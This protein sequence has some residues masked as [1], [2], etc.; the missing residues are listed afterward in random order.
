M[1]S[2]AKA[3]LPDAQCRED[4]FSNTWQRETY[5]PILF[6]C[7][8]PLCQAL[9]KA[10]SFTRWMW[11]WK[12]KKTPQHGFYNHPAFPLVSAPR[13]ICVAL[14]VLNLSLLLLILPTYKRF[15]QRW[16]LWCQ[17]CVSLSSRRGAAASQQ[18]A[19]VVWP[20]AK[21]HSPTPHFFS[22]YVHKCIGEHQWAQRRRCW[23]SLLHPRIINPTLDR[24]AE[25]ERLDTV[26]QVIYGSK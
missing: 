18:I 24:Q 8:L 2:P 21:Q 9:S 26:G 13:I 4:L 19:Q 23:H 11:K 22:K 1:T 6:Y 17:C 12:K 16:A 3:P 15:L 7:Y 25:P 10:H 14:V 5:A 20:T